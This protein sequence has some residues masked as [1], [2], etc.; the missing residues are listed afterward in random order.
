MEEGALV[1]VQCDDRSTGHPHCDFALE[2]EFGPTI[3][4][5]RH[6]RCGGLPVYLGV[7]AG[8]SSD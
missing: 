3:R 2:G 7:V 6:Q 1:V 5:G 8:V 4:A